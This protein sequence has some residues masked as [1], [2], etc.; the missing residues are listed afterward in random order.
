MLRPWKLEIQLDP[1]SEKAIYLQIADIIIQ[2]LRLGRIF[3]AAP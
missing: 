2:G 3:S 1:Q